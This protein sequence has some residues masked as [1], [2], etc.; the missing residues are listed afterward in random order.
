MHLL[1]NDASSSY[2]RFSRIDRLRNDLQTLPKNIQILNHHHTHYR[3]LTYND[4]LIQ[5]NLTP[6]PQ[7]LHHT[8][9]N[10]QLITAQNHA[11][12]NRLINEREVL[13]NSSSSTKAEIMAILTALMV[14]TPAATVIIHTDLQAAIDGYNKSSTEYLTTTL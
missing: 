3:I 4:Y 11:L 13:L 14:Y 1:E 9:V 7:I 8:P 5:R 12:I 6:L 10:S 2:S